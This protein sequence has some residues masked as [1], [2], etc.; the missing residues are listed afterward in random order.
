ML[1]DNIHRFRSLQNIL[2]EFLTMKEF[3]KL[4]LTFKFQKKIYYCFGH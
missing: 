2:L 1:V 3:Q 4:K